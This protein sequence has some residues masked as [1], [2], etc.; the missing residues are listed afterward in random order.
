VG[1]VFFSPLLVM[2]VISSPPFAPV[3]HILSRLNYPSNHRIV[4]GRSRYGSCRVHTNIV[5]Y[6]SAL[7]ADQIAA[8]FS[9]P[10]LVVAVRAL[11]Y[12]PNTLRWKI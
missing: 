10:S 8:R 11:V 9:K 7:G 2:D 5:S 6:R 4:I 1:C 12:L 3:S